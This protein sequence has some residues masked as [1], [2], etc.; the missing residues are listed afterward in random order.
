MDS[1][2]SGRRGG[3]GRARVE[4]EHRGREGEQQAGGE[5]EARDGAT[6]DASDDGAPEAALPA[7]L[8]G[9]AAEE[10]NA[11]R[12]HAIAQQRENGREQ[13]QGGDHRDEP[14]DDR[15]GGEAA[16][17]R[18]RNEQEAEHREHERDSA[19]EDGT[20]GGGTRGRDRVELLASLQP[21]L[22]VPGDGEERV[23][24]PEGEA[25]ADEHVLREDGEVVRLR[26]DRHERERDDDGG[27]R[28]HER[29]EARDDGAE[30]EQ[31]DDERQRGAEEELA[32]LQILERCGVFVG[33]RR[34]FAGHRR[35]VARLVVEPLHDVD[36]LVDIVLPVPAEGEE[37][38][39]RV[40]V[41][42]DQAPVLFVG[43]DPS[44]ACATKLVRESGNSRARRGRSS[45]AFGGS[46]DDDLRDGHP[47]RDLLSKG[48]VED[49]VG[50]LR[51]GRSRDLGL[52]LEREEGGHQNERG[53]DGDQP[54]T[55][56]EPG[57]STAGASEPLGHVGRT[58]S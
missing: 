23:V 2:R 9:R 26:Q 52:A 10:G 24:D 25:H 21:L 49:P 39:R 42:R 44:C 32:L 47:R 4:R 33:V 12:V 13:R 50:L 48:L 7:R 51:L 5:H 37:Q 41:L 18:A 17:D 45:V 58:G 22:P 56:D 55:D 20:A 19:E 35:P 36:D 3:P 8:L 28:E 6:H 15:A 54:E 27:H 38:D 16:E 29:H 46:D 31:Q 14:D 34:P 11:K 40:A 53:E 43:D 57:A 1:N 30:D